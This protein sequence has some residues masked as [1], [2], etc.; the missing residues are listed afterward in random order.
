MRMTWLLCVANLVWPSSAFTFHERE[1][2]VDFTDEGYVLIFTP[3][4]TVFTELCGPDTDDRHPGQRKVGCAKWQ[5]TPPVLP[6]KFCL[7]V[8]YIGVDSPARPQVILDAEYRHCLEGSYH[9]QEGHEIP[10]TR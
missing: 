7:M 3:D 1:T 2:T 6:A 4:R 9:D 8:V 10:S 5:D